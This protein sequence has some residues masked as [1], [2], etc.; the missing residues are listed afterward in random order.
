MR[1]Y[2]KSKGGEATSW[3][4]IRQCYWETEL[5]VSSY[6]RITNGM[7]YL[8]CELGYESMKLPRRKKFRCFCPDVNQ[9]KNKMIFGEQNLYNYLVVTQH[10]LWYV[11]CEDIYS[12]SPSSFKKTLHSPLPTFTRYI[13]GVLTWK[14]NIGSIWVS[15]GS[16]HKIP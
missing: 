15:L 12:T 4:S 6:N 1:P 11:N 9:R 5:S 3:L 7:N 8:Q 16:H 14:Q 10:K 13:Y 2:G